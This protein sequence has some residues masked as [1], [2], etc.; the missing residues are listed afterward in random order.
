M[1]FTMMAKAKPIKTGNS[2]RKLVLMMLADNA[3][4]SGQCFPSYQHVADVC[5]MSRRS[6]ITHIAALEKDGIVKVIHRK[7]YGKTEKKQFNSSN[8]YQLT[9]NTTI[10]TP[11]RGDENSA[12]PPSESITPPSATVAPPSENSAPPPSENSAPIPYHSSYPINEPI[13]HTKVCGLNLEGLPLK[14]PK[15]LITAYIQMRKAIKAPMTQQ[16]LKILVNK[17]LKL[18][19]LG[20]D[21]EEMLENA[22]VSNWKSVHPP[23]SQYGHQANQR[24]NP[25]NSERMQHAATEFVQSLQ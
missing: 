7:N 24:T 3:D 13:K 2:G 4:D 5:E 25:T 14:I 9:L 15:D 11:A 8:I 21:P 17:I 6:V 20:H 12:L 16:A 1:S 18:T 19:A 23:R 10:T 22:I